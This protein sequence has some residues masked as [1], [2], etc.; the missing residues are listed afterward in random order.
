MRHVHRELG[1]EIEDFYH[2]KHQ[3]ILNDAFEMSASLRATQFALHRSP[4]VGCGHG[5]RARV[6]GLVAAGLVVCSRRSNRSLK[7]L[8]VV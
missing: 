4:A 7:A 2:M 1:I 6:V 3:R 8:R 5:L